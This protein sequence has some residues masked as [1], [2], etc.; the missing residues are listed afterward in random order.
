MAYFQAKI[1]WKRFRKRENKNYHSVSF[2]LD[3]LQK[4]SKKKGKQFNKLKNT[5]IASF[6]AKV[7][8]KSARKGEN[9][10]YR[11]DSFLLDAL[12]KISKKKKKYHYGFISN[13]NRL[14]MDEK[15]RKKKF[16][17]ISFLHDA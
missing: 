3:A 12:Q 11:S 2:Q 1:G 15:Q 8:W 7:C 10:N 16:N 14:E 9:K 6:Q 17:S 4:I 5:I 13:Q